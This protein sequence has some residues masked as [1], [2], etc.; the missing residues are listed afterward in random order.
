M[1][2]RMTSR[3]RLVA[4]ARRQPPD[5]IPRIIEFE[6]QVANALAQ[7]LGIAPGDVRRYFKVDMDFVFLN[8]T[9]ARADFSRYFTHPDVEWDAWGCGRRWDAT[10]HYAEYL[11][12]LEQ[13]ERA[14]ELEQYPWP[15]DMLAYRYDGLAD[16]VAH[17]H[18]QG[19]AVFGALGNT[20]FETAWQL[21]S[22]G[23]LFEDI[24]T[25]DPLA[26]ILLDRITERRVAA[27]R[28]YARAGVDVLH[29][30]DDVAMQSDLLMSRDLF[31]TWFAPRYRRII[32]AAREEQPDILIHYHSDGDMTK[33]FPDL[34]A[35]G[36]DIQNPVQPE[37]VDHQ[38]I[39]A[40]YGD[41]I[42]FSGGLGVQSIL[43]FGTPEEVRE[44]T[45]ATINT[46]GAGGGFIV[47]PAHLIERDIPRENF[48]AMV[49]A[50]D[51]YG[52]YE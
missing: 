42:A 19:Q 16:R 45:R 50:I 8:P 9:H 32:T 13:C 33:L 28:A 47:G 41:R 46:L 49:E 31:N 51:R 17:W 15:D 52:M 36:I 23:R 39:K 29:L 1:K 48:V 18:A 25:D 4:A 10:R 5:R 3:E 20:I 24:L 12:P 14:D 7:E 38:A 35:L 27:A 43:P 22:M 26:T 40:A 30:A 2:A 34:I 6:G 21:R 11:Y 44:H 37:C